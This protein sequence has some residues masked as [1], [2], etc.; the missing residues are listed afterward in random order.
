[1]SK[2]FFKGRQDKREDHQN[3]SFSSKATLRPGTEKSPLTLVVNSPERKE[4]VE[5]QL[6]DNLLWGS[7]EVDLEAEENIVELTAVLNKPTTV[8]T[9]K[10]PK[11]NDPCLCGSGK[12]YKKCCA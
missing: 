2:F 10:L 5:A 8:T 7:I 9:D 3:H 6:Q 12:K 11:R 4:E 1:M